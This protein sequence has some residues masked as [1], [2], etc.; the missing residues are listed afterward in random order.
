MVLRRLK[1]LAPACALA[2]S[3]QLLLGATS[4]SDNFTARILSAHNRERLALGVPALQWDPELAAAAQDWADHLA[5]TGRFEH[6]PDDAAEPQGE[7]LW[8]GTRGYFGPEAM[9][10]AWVR[11]KRYFRP[12]TFPNNSTTGRVEDV[13]HYTQLVWRETGRVGCARAASAREDILVC[14]YSDA[15]NYRGE[16][17]F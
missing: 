15:G 6:A 16:R 17:P 9:V 8:A 5:A 3:S 7:N 14:R 11:E 2:L 1:S 4:F 13:G 10:D 12:G